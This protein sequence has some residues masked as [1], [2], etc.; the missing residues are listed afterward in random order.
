M[1]SFPFA[2]DYREKKNYRTELTDHLHD[3]YELVYVHSG[4]GAFFI[5]RSFDEM[6]EGDL[7]AIPGNTIHRAFPDKVDPV[8]STA[9]FFSPILIQQTPLGEPFSYLRCFEQAQARRRFK[10]NTTPALRLEIESVVDRMHDELEAGIP[11]F[12]HSVTLLL[13]GLLLAIHRE[14]SS[15]PEARAGGD[16]A[17]GWMQDILLYIDD[18]YC[19]NIGLAELSARASVSPAHF[20]RLFKQLTG[21][22]VTA[23]IAT[24][25]MIR[26]KELLLAS[27]DGVG[28]IAAACG[29]ESLPHFHRLFK[30]IVG[31]T[32]SAYRREASS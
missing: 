14:T 19:E 8:T 18:H 4:S 30:R 1:P 9:V 32:P 10:L 27:D 23:F 21:M 13:H 25:R 24:K 11:G 16:I 17:P 20:S 22:N 5:D 29:F 6:R 2:I 15:L 28:A 7:F 26:A 31:T 3:W 12:R